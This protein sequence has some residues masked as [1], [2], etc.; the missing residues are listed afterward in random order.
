MESL[1]SSIALERLTGILERL[2]GVLECLT[3]VPDLLGGV[4]SSLDVCV[5]ATGLDW[6]SGTGIAMSILRCIKVIND[7]QSSKTVWLICL[8][9][10][11]EIKLLASETMVV[12]CP[13]RS[14]VKA[15]ARVVPAGVPWAESAT[16]AESSS[17]AGSATPAESSTTSGS[18]PAAESWTLADSSSAESWS[19]AESAGPVTPAELANFAES[20]GPV[21]PA[22]LSIPSG[23][24]G[25]GITVIVLFSG[26]CGTTRDSCTSRL[27]M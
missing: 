27:D 17:C 20:V 3:G 22:K 15:A 19:S 1:D 24:G 18:S 25:D 6:V 9:R 11:G 14:G 8:G 21:T 10:D 13:C 2:T 26:A 7:K 12:S 16:P 4:R 5:W 23:L